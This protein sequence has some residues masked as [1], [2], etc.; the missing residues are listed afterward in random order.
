MR[1]PPCGSF[2]DLRIH[3][4][5]CFEIK[6]LTVDT[7]SGHAALRL[8]G[9]GGVESDDGYHDHYQYHCMNSRT[10]QILVATLAPDLTEHV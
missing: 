10:T 6:Y 4:L 8:T 9:K 3:F 7:S 5:A 2:N 1:G